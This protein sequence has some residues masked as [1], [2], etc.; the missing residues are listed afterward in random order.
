MN[1]FISKIRYYIFYIK[2]NKKIEREYYKML[3][4]GLSLIDVTCFGGAPILSSIKTTA[5][6]FAS[7]SQH[8]FAIKFYNFLDALS[9]NNNDEVET[10]KAMMRHRCNDDTDKLNNYLEQIMMIIDSYNENQKCYWLGLLFKAYV[11]NIISWQDFNE[12]CNAIN[13]LL[14]SDILHIMNADILTEKYDYTS[15]ENV[16][17]LASSNEKSTLVQNYDIVT[18]KI[19]K[20]DRRVYL[21]LLAVG[22]ASIDGSSLYMNKMP[23]NIDMIISSELECFINL[24][25][26]KNFETL[27][28]I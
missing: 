24:L 18:E 27:F 3:N 8:I 1:K 20:V 28:I 7:I 4:N 21:R 2:H 10:F 23:E 5:D 16:Y 6:F 15:I 13:Q 17:K 14:V 11:Y 9:V 19:I 25:S 26:S 12:Y 22:L